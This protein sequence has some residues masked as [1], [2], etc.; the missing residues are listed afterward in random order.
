MP[1]ELE[2]VHNIEKEAYPAPW[3]LNFFRIIYNMHRDLF[4]VAILDGKIIGYAVGEVEKREKRH[5]QKKIGHVMNLAVIESH[6]EKGIGTLLMDE[7]EH[8]FIVKGASIAYLEV[9]ESNVTAQNLY[10]RRGYMFVN[11]VDNYYGDENGLLMS[12]VLKS[13]PSKR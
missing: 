3:T 5:R 4:I 8:R 1:E 11:K 12:K 9:R 2:T 13:E 7:I 6:R 10:S